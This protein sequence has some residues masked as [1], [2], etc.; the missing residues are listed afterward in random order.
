MAQTQGSIPYN[1][2]NGVL[3]FFPR[4]GNR[5]KRGF[6]SQHVHFMNIKLWAVAALLALAGTSPLRAQIGNIDSVSPTTVTQN[7]TINISGWATDPAAPGGTLN[8]VFIFVDET[9]FNQGGSYY[10]ATTGEPNGSAIPIDGDGASGFSASIP[11]SDLSV[12]T[13]TICAYGEVWWEDDNDQYQEDQGPVG[14]TYTVNVC[15]PVSF[16]FS[17]VSFTYNGSAQGPAITPSDPN[18]TYS[19]SGTSATSAGTYIVTA[20]GT[21]NYLGTNSA[22]WTI[23]QATPVISWSAPAAITYG[24]TLSPTQLSATA[25]VPGSFAYTPAAGT[26]LGAG[27]HTL[28][29]VFT[30]TDTTDYTSASASV[31]LTVNKATPVVSWTAP[32]AITYGTALSSTQLNATANV[33]GTF[34]YTPAAGTI[35]AAGA[36]TLSVV[37]TPTDT[38]DY[39]SATA[40]VSL[41]VNKATPVISWAAPSTITYGVLLSATQLD[42][43]ANAPGTF[44]YTP[45]AGNEPAAGAHT[46][47][48]AFTPTDTTDYN[49]ASASVSLTVNARPVTFTI[50]PVSFTYNGSA[51][52]PT[53]TPA[54]TGATYATSGTASATTAGSY[55]VTATATGNYT[56]TSGATAWTI[57]KATP[58][59]SNWP[60]NRTIVSTSYTVLAA[61]LSAVFSN[62]TSGVTEPTGTVTYSIVSGGSGAVTAGKVLSAGIY[63]IAA[64][65][66]GDSNYNATT[67]DVTWTISDPITT[68]SAS[69]TSVAFGQTVTIT[70]ISTDPTGKLTNQAIDYLVPGSSTW[71][72]GSSVTGANWSGA[73]TS[74]HTLTWT[75]PVT[76]LK[77]LGVWQIRASGTN[78]IAT[79]VY[80]TVSVTLAKAT[81]VV[82]SWAAHTFTTTHTVAAAD[83]S[84]AFANPYTTSVTAP[85]GTVTYSIVAGGSG[86]VTTGTVIL[87]GTYTICASYPGDANYNATTV[88]AVWTISN[89]APVTTI[90]ASPTSITLG[91]TTTITAK[92][93]DVDSNLKSQV[94]DYLPPG[95]STWVSG[96]SITG[97]NWSGSPTASNT[98]AWA[99]PASVIK[100]AGTWQIRASGSDG[101][102]TSAYATTSITVAKAT[103]VV[104]NWAVRTF[105]TTHT[106]TAADL[107]A[108][109]VN[110]TTATGTTQPTG[111]VTYQHVSSP[112]VV[113]TVILPGTY[114]ITASYAGDSDY[115]ATTA[116]VTWT[117]SNQPPVTTIAANSVSITFGQTVTI[118]ATTTDADANLISQTVDYLAPGSST[119]VL[120]SSAAGT[121]WSG[122]ATGSHTLTWTVPASIIK[123]GTWQIRSS[124]S[125]GMATSNVATVSITVAKA[126]PVAPNYWAS[127]TFTGAHTVVSGDLNAAFANPYSTSVTQPTGTVTYKN[128]SSPVTAG[129]VLQPGVYTIYASYPGDANYTAATT[130]VTWTVNSSASSGGSPVTNPVGVSEP[131]AWPTLAAADPNR[132]KVAVGITTGQLSVDK[133]GAANYTIALYACPGTAGMEPKLSLNY[134]SQAGAGILGFGWSLGGTSVITR[135]A[136]SAAIDGNG[137]AID[138]NG[139][140]TYVHGMHFATTDRYYLDGQRLIAINGETYGANNTEYRTEQDSFSRIVSYGTNGNG[141]AYFMVWTKAGLIME[142]G[143]T[144]DSALVPDSA[145]TGATIGSTLSWSVDKISDTKGNY[146]TFSYSTN[147]TASADSALLPGTGAGEQ[148]L[149]EIDYTGN[150]NAG[151][152]PYNSIKFAYG[153]RPDPSSGYVIGGQVSSTQR[154]TQISA[155]GRDVNNNV[156]LVHTYAMDYTPQANTNS[157]RT[158]LAGVVESGSDGNAYP[159][160]TFAYS[161]PSP[162]FD[163]TQ[164]STFAPPVPMAIYNGPAQGTGFIDLNGDGRPDFVQYHSWPGG[165]TSNAWLNTPTGWVAQPAYR[166]PYPLADDSDPNG[167]NLFTRF[168]DLN[169]DGLP[170]YFALSNLSDVAG[171]AGIAQGIAYTNTGSGWAQSN[172]W[173]LPPPDQTA[174]NAAMNSL[175]NPGGDVY[176]TGTSFYRQNLQFVDLNG[177]GLPD[178]ICY[179]SL[180]GW[181]SDGSNVGIPFPEAWV[182]L[183]PGST[184]SV[185]AGWQYAPQYLIPVNSANPNLFNLTEGTVF[186]DVNGDGLPD[187]VQNYLSNASVGSKVFQ[188]VALNT[189]NGWNVLSGADLARY[190]PPQ[191]INTAWPGPPYSN[192]PIGTEM[193]DLNGDGLADFILRNDPL[194]LNLTCFNTGN[195]WVQAPS[196]FLAPVELYDDN[197][198]AGTALLDIDNDGV[199]DL[200]H[201]WGSDHRVYLGSGTGWSPQPVSANYNPPWQIA[202]S[203]IQ[204]TGADFVDL[205]GDGA[206]DEVWN[207]DANGPQVSSLPSSSGAA[208]NFRVN[209]DRL[210]KVTTGMGVSA[211]I[212]YKPLTDPTVYTKGSG[213]VYPEADVI[214][215]MYVVS[216]VD[217]DDG[218]G[219]Q[220]EM[221][222][223]YSVLRSNVLH[224]DEGFAS[225]TVKDSRTGISTVTKFRQDYP[226]IG[227]PSS[228]TTTQASGAILTTNTTTWADQGAYTNVHFPYASQVVEMSYELNGVFTSGT[229]T[230][231][232]YDS[233]GNALTVDTKS[234][235]A[236]GNPTTGYEKDTTSIY[237]NDTTHWFLG[238]LSSASVASSAPGVPTLTR[239]SAFAYDSTSGLLTQEVVEPNDTS[240]TDPLK[241]TTTYTY[242]AFGN[243][244]SATISGLGLAN[245]AVATAYDSRGQFPLSTTNALGH[246]ETYIYDPRWGVM[247]SQTGPNGLT[248]TWTYDGMGRKIME[249]RP[250]GTVTEINYRWASTAAPAAPTGSV[251]SYL[252]ETE[253]SGAPPSLAFYD[254]M[255]RAIYAFGIN[256]GDFDGNPKIVGTQTQYDSY[257]RAYWTS[258]PFYYGNTPVMAAEVTHYDILNRPLTQINADEEISGGFVTSTFAYNGLVT[259]VTNPLG[260]ITQTTKN[261]QGQVLSVVTNA[262]LASGSPGRGE[263]DYTY[264]APGDVLATAVVNSNGAAVATSFTY[265]LS[266]RKIKMIDPDMGTWTYAYDAAGELV[267][268]TDAKNQ[269]TTMAYDVLGRL[270]T[271]TEAEGT[272]TWTYDTAPRGGGV[273]LGA[274]ASV[275]AP[276]NYSESYTYDSLGRPSVTTRKINTGSITET[277]TL[278]Q[279]Y[280]NVGRPSV[281]TYPGGYQVQNIYNAFGFLQEVSQASASTNLVNDTVQNQVFWQADSYS[282]WGGVNGC[283]YGN[284]ITEDTV[285]A[286]TTGRVLGFGIGLNEGVA[287]Y[288]YVHDALGNLVT[289]NDAATGRN[290]TYT[291]DGL[292]RLTSSALTI[293][294]G[295]LGTAKTVT[296]GYDSLGNILNKSDVGAYTYGN[297]A[298]PHAVTAA[299]GN[300][301]AYDADGN[302]TSGSVLVS[303]VSTPRTLAWTSFNQVK[304]ITQGSHS[305]T[306]T[307]DAGHQ[308]ATQ[309]T[310]QGATVY[311]GSAFERVTTGSDVKYKF[312]IFTPAGRSVVR[313]VDAGTVTTRYL[314]QDALGSIV[315]VTDETGAVAERYA[316]D[317]WGNQTT[318]QPPASGLSPATTRG[319]TD[320]EMLP[321]LGLIHMNGRVYD[322]TLGRF[323]SADSVV[324]APGDS[325]AY[326]RYSY[327]SNNP[328][329]AVDPSGHSWLSKLVG[330]MNFGAGYLIA[331]HFFNTYG[332]MIQSIVAVA[333]FSY[334]GM[335]EVGAAVGGFISGFN[336][337]LLNGGSIGD[338]FR[339]GVI[340]AAEGFAMAYIGGEAG[341]GYVG[342]AAADGAIQGAA[343]E[344]E[345]GQFRNGFYSGFA[346][347]LFS[348]GTTG[349]GNWYLGLAESAVA[350]GTVSVIGGGKFA[351][352][353]ETAAFTY[354]VDNPPTA[355]ELGFDPNNGQQPG[356]VGYGST[357]GPDY[358]AIKDVPGPN[359]LVIS[360][361]TNMGSFSYYYYQLEDWT[362]TALKGDGYSLEENLVG[363]T[364][365]STSNNEFVPMDNGVATDIVGWAKNDANGN[366]V[367]VTLPSNYNTD[368]TFT[369]TFTV[370]YNG[371]DYPLSTQFQHEDKAVNGQPTN[372]VTVVVP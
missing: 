22:N 69:A 344:A 66:P 333:I 248:T 299:G 307:F 35:L 8:V 144:T 367:S 169:G 237:N 48:V 168:V 32:A 262:G 217:N 300:S 226:F 53:I 303:G 359:S 235:D 287:F 322:P 12:G 98:L 83:L 2:K 80:A 286:N 283:T 329:N 105:A 143:H 57:A 255:G 104:S 323:L 251:T 319:F 335:P 200:L 87:P 148:L 70:A 263:T 310:D 72:S 295:G 145:A 214:N 31:S 205:N 268:Q 74:S 67:A 245:R 260:Q 36:H 9:Y 363:S 281:T 257:G 212:T 261:S 192:A 161:D 186:A 163:Q 243:K 337:S 296:I 139:N 54:G 173:S 149:T 91:Q 290:E 24:T 371:I 23:A 73:A 249:T 147:T 282:L 117:V 182:N 136:E 128:G 242:D 110:P 354:V 150:A 101:I 347:A 55:S 227:M 46:L 132:T 179:S 357:T 170:D 99:A 362:G 122:S 258:L 343:D 137:S 41:T 231:T 316:Y 44:V 273:W 81:P 234:L 38:T 162:G 29:V 239:T 26:I 327:C 238:R 318:L 88:D 15:N 321:E 51:Q 134:S 272:T 277:F 167:L 340:G 157:H 207:W 141:P 97:A 265:D 78:N 58:V 301:Y 28:S 4:H 89:T 209:P 138:G 185:G 353:A 76:I 364:P 43:T 219:A 109:F 59:V 94:I 372:T 181:Y 17:P 366:P 123:A 250:D 34:A 112:V 63:T 42:A 152:A 315:A 129:T 230:T 195:G 350:G 111:T 156:V 225:M 252:I 308:R 108:V 60:N 241:L 6:S 270:V 191:E 285:V 85:S 370:R 336:S 326:N 279:A 187:L 21:G 204:S 3:N 215:P 113:G 25:N 259:Q 27:S 176:L 284:G 369:Q 116:S 131:A 274:L 52:G 5:F 107:T 218:T 269:N 352:G 103:P 294:T 289:R 106:V 330:I 115:N 119:W 244:T 159:E 302:M 304:N 324:Q 120:G 33:P 188:G 61:D 92:T 332:P 184:S 229:S 102:A 165:S 154:L 146:M 75:I 18:A 267:L 313:T 278:G 358:A 95:S 247:T 314:H 160:L 222:Y 334:F 325:Q 256:G 7:Q 240:T 211:S 171:P 220:Y 151:V 84:A 20:T 297:K 172:R 306:F 194:N 189:G 64:S 360:G 142:F 65:Y 10:I 100:T 348:A 317:P 96:A 193:I 77:T 355:Q 1:L 271:R 49:S 140:A 68:I 158:R 233:Y 177:D 309:T 349:Q 208:F 328:V 224:G 203:N 288:G 341:L 164:S 37:F 190:L 264:D 130:S 275:T 228:T 183:G 345:G 292:N 11:A 206:V 16:T 196:S 155:Y 276:N 82:S 133:S 30:P 280:D 174:L 246:Q 236:S 320:H 197:T 71:V 293:G 254:N 45:A 198:S 216:A 338:A 351:N 126:T 47:S 253:A 312:Y 125:D 368:Q 221:D 40:S 124:G 90:S 13:H 346:G 223:T 213:A 311:V 201:L 166:L 331:P 153:S 121:A 266:G 210:I 305:S 56:G 175:P 180:V 202:D 135:G 127:Q 19:T 356:I 342:T 39:T 14:N 291:Y 365:V 79:S 50:A 298:G 232:T 114:T 118:T 361:F 86:T 62:S 93:T 199:V 339:N 178:C